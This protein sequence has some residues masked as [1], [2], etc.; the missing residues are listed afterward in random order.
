MSLERYEK[1]EVVRVRCAIARAQLL[2]PHFL[3]N[4]VW[5]EALGEGGFDLEDGRA[6]IFALDRFGKVHI[7]KRVRAG[8]AWLAPLITE[9]DNFKAL[10]QLPRRIK[11][12]QPWRATYFTKV[13][14][15]VPTRDKE[16]GQ[17]VLVFPG[18]PST[19]YYFKDEFVK[20]INLNGWI[21]PRKQEQGRP[22]K[23]G[24]YV[25]KEAEKPRIW[26][27][28]LSNEEEKRLAL[29]PVAEAPAIIRALH[30]RHKQDL[31]DRKLTILDIK[32]GVERLVKHLTK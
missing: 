22:W 8:E 21:T 4:E 23:Q 26:V 3:N 19:S 31:K 9:V 32:E 14:V 15:A 16:T 20:G 1:R 6:R 28:D 25:I 7:Y 17:F 2:R 27:A 10:A 18:K 11:V 29:N 13:I 30:K 5:E 12:K 24:G